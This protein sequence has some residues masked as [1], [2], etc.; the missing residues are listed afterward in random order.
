MFDSLIKIEIE[1]IVLLKSTTTEHKH[2][3][4]F[5]IILRSFKKGFLVNVKPNF[6]YLISD[7][8]SL[9][10]I[11]WGTETILIGL[12]AIL[13]I[14]GLRNAL[15]PLSTWDTYFDTYSKEFRRFIWGPHFFSCFI[16]KMALNSPFK[17]FKLGSNIDLPEHPLISFAN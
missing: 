16:L 17:K 10:Y 13:P 6:C 4:L 12:E 14:A 1:S 7:C 11:S 9:A 2:L 3:Y 5:M 8:W 15:H